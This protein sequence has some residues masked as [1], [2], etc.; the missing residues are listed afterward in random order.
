M[1]LRHDVRSEFDA[2]LCQLTLQRPTGES[3]PTAVAARK[4]ASLRA[5]L[6]RSWQGSRLKFDQMLDVAW[7][8]RPS[9]VLP[10]AAVREPLA[11]A[12][13][14]A[15]A[16]AR[17]SADDIF[18]LRCRRL[19]GFWG[20]FATFGLFAAGLAWV[21]WYD[22]FKQA[23]GEP[24]SLTSGTS[25]WPAEVLRL[26]VFALA[27]VFGFG[28]S[29]KMSETF[30][31][32]TREFRLSLPPEKDE[33]SEPGSAQ[34]IWNDYLK[35]CRFRRRWLPILE[36]FGLYC[37]FL[38]AIFGLFG[39]P[40][41]VPARG[42]LVGN[43]D[44]VFLLASI[45]GFLLLAFLTVDA[46]YSCHKFIDKLG[47]GPVRFPEAT[48][49]HFAREKGRLAGEYL[50]E[51]INLQLIAELTE[52]VGR[53]VYYPAGLLLLLFLARNSWWDCWSWPWSLI[54]IYACNLTLALASV[55][56]LQQAAKAAKRKAEKSLTAKVRRLQAVAAPSIAENNSAQAQQLLEEIK[57]LNRGAFVPF[58]ENPVVG[59]VFLSSGGTTML[60]AFIWFMGR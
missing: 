44:I 33:P 25:A 35:G 9:F 48:R 58:W 18:H 12:A 51:W 15:A 38:W 29:H 47:A 37:A 21:A 6:E 20:G 3:S 40:I 13:L 10:V 19:A 56:I 2:A 30:Y 57:Q 5:F 41:F 14:E 23:K 31:A 49:R 36:V 11:K 45:Y 52:Q 59:A 26:L 4:G 42:T 17:E 55:I 53:L 27:A 39:D 28:L 7:G 22:T 60:Q 34:S 46:A 32:L 1:I 50:D 24:F 8:S 16:A 43:A 54:V